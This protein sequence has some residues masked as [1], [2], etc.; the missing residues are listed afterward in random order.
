V[1]S[2]I[3]RSPLIHVEV[4]SKLS[5]AI[6]SRHVDLEPSGQG[7]TQ[8]LSFTSVAFAASVR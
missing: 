6:L 8:Y 5:L 7:N 2:V 3:S 1:V 4:Y